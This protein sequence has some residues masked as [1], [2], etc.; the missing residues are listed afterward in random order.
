MNLSMK[1]KCN[2]PHISK[3]A[4]LTTQNVNLSKVTIKVTLRKCEAEEVN[5]LYS[6]DIA[7][8]LK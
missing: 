1:P 3:N 7:V 4:S 5:K 8:H 2:Y 6:N